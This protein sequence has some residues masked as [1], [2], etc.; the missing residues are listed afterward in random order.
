[1]VASLVFFLFL[2]QAG[3]ADAL[4][5]YGEGRYAEAALAY[6]DLTRSNPASADA[7]AGLGKSL[8]KLHNPAAIP[9]LGRALQLK[10]GDPDIGR[11]LAQGYLEGGNM[12]GAVALLESITEKNPKD[13]E[14]LFLL[15][16]AMY[17]GGFYQR[18]AQLLGQALALRPGI[19]GADAMYAVSLAKEGRTAEAEVAC[20]R[21][22]AKPPADWDL[23]VS[24]TYVEILDDTGRPGEAMVYADKVLQQ[25]PQ[26]PIAHFWKARLLLQS[27]HIEDAAKEAEQS[28]TFA[29]GLP[30][31][32]NL[33][34]QI[35]RR[36]G[37]TEDAE[38]QADWLREYNNRL[39][40]LAR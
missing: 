22:L 7:W 26:N 18:A 29:P 36:E 14:A 12:A 39:T 16:E 38:R 11:T 35:Y 5:M 17:R 8:L 28:V 6:R 33:L 10:P 32:R 31:A 24:L 27:G 21:L 30:L 19:P 3:N 13:P 2:M 20:L 37:R 4:R 40:G 25:L 9:I 15:G 1:M 23:D 34:V